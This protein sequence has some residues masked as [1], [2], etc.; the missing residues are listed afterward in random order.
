MHVHGIDILENCERRDFG[1]DWYVAGVREMQRY[2]QAI[3][4]RCR[5]LQTDDHDVSVHR[6]EQDGLATRYGD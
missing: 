3:A 5:L 1:G 4:N 6:L 2:R